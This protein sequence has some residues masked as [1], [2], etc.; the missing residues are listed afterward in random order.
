MWGLVHA[1][2]RV[3]TDVNGITFCIP[4]Y[5]PTETVQKPERVVHP[6]KT[7]MTLG[8]STTQKL[9]VWC[10]YHYIG[11]IYTLTCAN[12]VDRIDH[13]LSTWAM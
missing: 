12:V 5:L 10:I 8:K 11:Y 4:N 2:V 1:R 6:W 13:T 3:G 7:K 9:N